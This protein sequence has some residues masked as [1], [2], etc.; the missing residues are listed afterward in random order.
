MRW[1]NQFKTLEQHLPPLSMNGSL[2]N[3]AQLHS[4]DM[5]NNVFQ[6]HTSSNNPLPPNKPGDRPQ[7]R[8]EH[9]NY[10]GGVGEN[11][12]AYADNVLDGHIGF[13]IDWGESLEG[14]SLHGMQDP[15]GHREKHS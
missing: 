11:I 3:A 9:Q 13:E 2:T 15:P 7:D 5:F 12:Y 6:G 8:G 10:Y 14:R 4:Q 1:F